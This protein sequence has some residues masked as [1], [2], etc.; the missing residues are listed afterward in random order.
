M[1]KGVEKFFSLCPAQG[2]DRGLRFSPLPYRSSRE[3][4]RISDFKPVLIY[5]IEGQTA[6][7]WQERVILVLRALQFGL[8]AL[9]H[10]PLQAGNASRPARP[11]DSPRFP[12][13][14]TGPGAKEGLG[15]YL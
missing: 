4:S 3:L 10:F 6:T 14:S 8:G 7:A 11:S 13:T 9:C 1:R 2:N 5:L 15:E 12:Q